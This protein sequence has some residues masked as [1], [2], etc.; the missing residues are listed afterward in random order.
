VTYDYP[1][2]PAEGITSKFDVNA[3]SGRWYISA[4]L[5][6]VFDCY[7]CQVHFFD[8]PG[9]G[10]VVGDLSWR[11]VEPDGEFVTRKAIQTFVQDPKNPGILYNHDNAYLHYE[12][13]WYI[14][15]WD[16][17]K[18]G[19]EFI[20][21]YYRGRNDA[22]D[23]YGGAVLY[24]RALSTPQAI[25]PRVTEACTKAGIDFT[26]FVMTDNTCK[27][28]P[29]AA[30]TL[31]LREAMAEKVVNFEERAIAEK[32]TY[33]RTVIES[34]LVKEEQ[35]LESDIKTFARSATTALVAEEKEVLQSLQRIEQKVTRFESDLD[36][37]A[38]CKRIQSTSPEATKLRDDYT[39]EEFEKELAS[40]DRCN[41]LVEAYP[42]GASRLL[43]LAL[44]AL[45][46]GAAAALALQLLKLRESATGQMSL[47]RASRAETSS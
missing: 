16:T 7:P 23:G 22:W 46:A 11:V 9:P 41:A 19:E 6:K 31:R 8:S 12:D 38:K 33:E 45:F 40:C 34:A 2:P 24:T 1:V 47:F 20:L 39:T 44:G 15:D 17:S 21:V 30:T 43:A 32:L 18:P 26:K 37:C 35:V 42:S 10:K 36:D 4:G 14:L 27:A 3:F 28:G 5:N 13:D 25:I 29:D